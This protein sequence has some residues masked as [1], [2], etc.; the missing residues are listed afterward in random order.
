MQD[1]RK[2]KN[3]PDFVSPYLLL[4]CRTWEEAQRDIEDRRREIAEAVAVPPKMIRRGRRL[5]D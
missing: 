3:N 5:N 2:T 4:P 1:D